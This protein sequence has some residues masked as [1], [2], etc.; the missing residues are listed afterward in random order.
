MFSMPGCRS[1]W[2]GPHRGLS[3]PCSSLT[4]WETITESPFRTKSSVPPIIPPA[5]GSNPCQVPARLPGCCRY[6]TPQSP[7]RLARPRR[8][9]HTPQAL[10]TYMRLIRAL[11]LPTH[12]AVHL[13][14]S[15]AQTCTQP[16]HS[17]DATSSSRP[18]CPG[19]LGNLIL[20]L[21]FAGPAHLQLLPLSTSSPTGLGLMPSQRF[22]HRLGTPCQPIIEHSPISV[23][24]YPSH[25]LI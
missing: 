1:L 4:N 7:A 15:A 13:P 11:G 9:A 22:G 23:Y 17:A 5:T 12:T 19:T 3:R 10:Q 24:T 20:P 21:R 25:K 8:A 6:A 16:L 18:C 2:P 14:P